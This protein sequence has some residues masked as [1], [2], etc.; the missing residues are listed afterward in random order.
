MAR[1]YEVSMVVYNP[2]AGGLLTGK[3][4][5]DSYTPG[6]RF[7]NNKMYQERYWHEDTF[8][9]VEGLEQLAQQEN[10]SL[11]SVALNWVMRHSPVDCMILG[12]TSVEQLDMNLST[13][14][15]GPLSENTLKA[16]DVIWGALRGQTPNYNR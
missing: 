15:H 8:D 12:A 14:A 11:I 1:A 7:D 9:A 10:R 4:K 2:L 6:T 5:R 13:L 16:C 3:H